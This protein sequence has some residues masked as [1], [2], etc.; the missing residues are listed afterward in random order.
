MISYYRSSTTSSPAAGT[1]RDAKGARR[2]LKGGRV[3]P[4]VPRI[5]RY[6]GIGSVRRSI[7]QIRVAT[8]IQ[9]SSI[10]AIQPLAVP[11]QDYDI[12]LSKEFH[13]VFR[14]CVVLLNPIVEAGVLGLMTSVTPDPH[15]TTIRQWNSRSFTQAA[16]Y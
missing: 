3:Q 1:R 14:A 2:F 10:M 16:V 9:L 4:R 13:T 11:L 5:S 8:R 15:T 12:P 6:E 7:Y